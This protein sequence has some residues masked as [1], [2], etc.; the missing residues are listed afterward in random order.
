[1]T[2]ALT[3]LAI[4]FA[5]YGIPTLPMIPELVLLL[6]LNPRLQDVSFSRF[7]TRPIHVNGTVVQVPL[8]NL[9][10]LTVEGDSCSTLELVQRLDYP[11]QMEHISLN[12][13]RCAPKH[14]LDTLGRLARDHL[15]CTGRSQGNLGIYMRCYPTTI[16]ILAN[17]ITEVAGQ[18]RRDTFTKFT[19]SLRDGIVYNDYVKLCTDFVAHVPVQHVVHFGGEMSMDIVK[20]SVIIMPNIKELHL[21]NAQLEPGF[22]Q[23]EPPAPHGPL[24]PSLQRLCLEDVFSDEGS[25]QPLTQFLVHQRVAVED[26]LLTLL[27]P[28]EHICKDVLQEILDVV[29]KL[30]FDWLTDDFCPFERCSST[31]EEEMAVGESQVV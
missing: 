12:V 8:K 27:G 6:S 2:G 25:W 13:A 5:N 9:Q 23:L 22:L 20:K 21:V 30:A 28:H 1:M 14:I 15:Q 16:S 24:L 18:A 3:T 11:T 10:C 19:A 26:I 17:A 29:E 4:T 7:W 31:G